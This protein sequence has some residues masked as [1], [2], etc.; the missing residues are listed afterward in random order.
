[1]RISINDISCEVEVR[2]S[3]QPI[4]FIHGFPLD[5]T[6]WNSQLDCF[7]QSYRVIAP[8]LRGFGQSHVTTGTVS[9]NQYS[10]DLNEI[11]DQLNITEPVILCGLSMGGYI[12]WEFIRNY[13][14][15]V[16]AI[17]LCDTRAAADSPE[18]VG[19]RMKMIE[20]IQTEGTAPVTTVMLPKLFSTESLKN[21][22]EIVNKIKETILNT[23]TVGI[24]AALRGMA[25][26]PDST[27]L[28]SSI[29]KPTL[30]IVGEEDQLTP[31]DEMQ[32]M[33][34]QIPDAEITVIKGAGHMSPMECPDQVN[35]AIKTFLDTHN[36]E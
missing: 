12:S 30:L 8:D 26:R 24:V 18:A 10:H 2:G 32:G 1:M 27:E 17:I 3:G 11:L 23:L 35:E 20:T 28:L 14:D 4:L 21:R 16:K 6:M 5:H 29:Q 22:Q 36:L 7:S 9:M 19:N 13:P 34:N 15:R 25:E 31:V 33:A